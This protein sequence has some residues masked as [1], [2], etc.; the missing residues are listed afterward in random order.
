[1]EA[2][3]QRVLAADS[4]WRGRV[5][6]LDEVGSTN[7][8]VLARLRAGEPGPFALFAER[9]HAGRGRRGR[10]WSGQAGASLLLSIAWPRRG[11][12]TGTG[13]S[14]QGG[15][16]KASSAADS[17]GQ[18]GPKS[19]PESS[20]AP[21]ISPEHNFGWMALAAGLALAR[22]A[23]TFG[24]SPLIKWPNDLILGEKKAAGVL[25][26]RAADAAGVCL[27]VGL[28]V[29]QR[30]ADFGPELAAHATSLAAECGEIALPPR[31]Q[32]AAMLLEGL[33][34]ALEEGQRNRPALLA[35]VERR[36]RWRGQ[37]VRVTQPQQELRGVLLGLGPVGELRLGTAQKE[38]RVF[39]GT[40]RV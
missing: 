15:S 12:G 22:L 2:E 4:R 13:C 39:E 21:E 38:L 37:P 17:V 3:L 6:W 33:A 31:P 11:V 30:P 28:N 27:G 14:E 9:Q 36:L 35:E 16:V 20:V 32:L 5:R 19:A 7:D 25:V 40:L 8:E 34:D 24:Q 23:E 1:M 10:A 29:N 26:E 18:G